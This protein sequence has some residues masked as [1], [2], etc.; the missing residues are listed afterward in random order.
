MLRSGSASA[1]ET[2]QFQT[3]TPN[4]SITYSV[5]TSESGVMWF[6]KAA[7]KQIVKLET[8]GSMVEYP[9]T[10]FGSNV[11]TV[12]TGLPALGPDGNIWYMSLE[13]GIHSYLNRINPDG[14]ISI[15]ELK[16]LSNE[17]ATPYISHSLSL[18]PDG[19]FWTAM[20][21][22]FDDYYIAKYDSNGEVLEELDTPAGSPIY[23][24]KAGISDTMWYTR[25]DKIGKVNAEGVV[26]E[27]PMPTNHQA[28]GLEL[29]Q[30]G[31][32]WFTAIDDKGN[33]Q[34]SKL[35]V[36]KITLAG[37]FTL[38][39]TQETGIPPAWTLDL[40][41]DGKLWFSL[42]G[43]KKMAVV[44]MDG[45]IIYHN[46]SPLVL[47]S[48]NKG[49]DNNIWALSYDPE[50]VNV[51]KILLEL[52][53]EVIDEQIISNNLLVNPPYSPRA[54]NTTIGVIVGALLVAIFSL[55]FKYFSRDKTRE[56]KS[57]R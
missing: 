7:Q 20:V 4:T 42:I 31:N 32:M 57:P 27:Y 3:P 49:P 2:Q 28:F 53:Q 12:Q 18:G 50:G 33:Q 1:L 22:N 40:G 16:T 43:A 44:S 30:D 9:L 56:M 51:V 15:F 5:D 19:H 41:P 47:M 45:S 37:E 46:F 17:E 55:M 26:T 14:S 48:A 54:G 34:D 29:A 23:N 24:I 13:D 10:T 38:Y 36:G 11:N 39:P 6:L 52:E 35:V 25:P 8:D 21:R